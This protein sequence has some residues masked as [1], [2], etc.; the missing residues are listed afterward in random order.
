M[1]THVPLIAMTAH[2]MQGD[3]ERCLQAGMDAYVAKPIHARDLF[4][5]IE[6]LAP[7][8]ATLTSSRPVVPVVNDKAGVTACWRG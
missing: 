7:T 5:A 2:A 4:L 6:Y 8:G 1:G 3:R